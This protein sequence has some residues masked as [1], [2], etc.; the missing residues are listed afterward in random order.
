M[1]SNDPTLQYLITLLRAR[2]AEL[3]E[4]KERGALSIEMAI[5]VAVLVAGGI[6]LSIFLAAKL[7]EKENAIK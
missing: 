5:L 1:I 3:R 7:T 4:E 6:G 2:F